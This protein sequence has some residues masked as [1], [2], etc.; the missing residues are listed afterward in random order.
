[1]ARSTFAYSREA[2][3]NMRDPLRSEYYQSSQ[4]E[5]KSDKSLLFSRVYTSLKLRDTHS[6]RLFRF[7]I[8][9]ILI[10]RAKSLRIRAVNSA[11]SALWI[12]FSKS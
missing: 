8:V 6:L 1:M 4:I 12:A 11:M 5:T 3:C 2:I 10:Q 9:A 7:R